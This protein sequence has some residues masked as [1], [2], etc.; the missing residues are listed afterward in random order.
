MIYYKEQENRRKNMKYDYLVAG[1][2]LYGSFFDYEVKRKRKYVLIID[3]ELNYE[4]YNLSKVIIRREYSSQWKQCSELYYHI[5][6]EKNS[7][8]HLE[9]KNWNIKVQGELTYE[10]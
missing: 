10:N 7:R 3:K 1:S 2:R 9:D 8:L 6:N 5:N 4:G